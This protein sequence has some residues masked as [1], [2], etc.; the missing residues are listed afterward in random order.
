MINH[1]LKP[2]STT[3]REF[4]AP[5]PSPG[6][7]PGPYPQLDSP[8][9]I[10]SLAKNTNLFLCVTHLQTYDKTTLV[11]PSGVA[12]P[13]FTLHPLSR[14][15][16]GRERIHVLSGARI[17]R[18][19]SSSPKPRFRKTAET[20][21][22]SPRSTFPERQRVYPR[23]GAI[24]RVSN[25]STLGNATPFSSPFLCGTCRAERNGNAHGHAGVQPAKKS[26]I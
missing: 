5:F 23:R 25:A 8:Q 3:R 14:T 4:P 7:Q 11:P 17:P 18:P 1:H 9:R 10:R 22:R 12:V 19:V 6:P 24:T 20:A 16:I 21:S 13:F 15:H 26:A 2:R